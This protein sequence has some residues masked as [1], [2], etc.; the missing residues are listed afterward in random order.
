M[1]SC[2]TNVYPIGENWVGKGPNGVQQFES[3]NDYTL[4]LKA[5]AAQGKIC[6]D[7]SVPVAPRPANSVSTPFTGFLEFKSPHPELQI[8]SAM[9]P[10]WG[11]VESSTN[12][13]AKGLFKTSS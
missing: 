9:S 4:Y 11:G 12:A 2:L 6:P 1:S 8:Y 3:L 13:V 7:V 5:L 10:N